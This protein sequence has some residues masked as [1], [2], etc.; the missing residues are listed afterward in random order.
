MKLFK[1]LLLG[2]AIFAMTGCSSGGGKVLSLTI[3][4]SYLTKLKSGDDVK[5]KDTST[6]KEIYSCFTTSSDLKDDSGKEYKLYTIKTNYT[7]EKL[8]NN[9]G[10]EI[11]YGAFVQLHFANENIELAGVPS[12]Y[13]LEDL[14]YV[15]TFTVAP[16]DVK[17]YAS[18]VTL[19]YGEGV[20]NGGSIVFQGKFTIKKIAASLPVE[21]E[22]AEEYNVPDSAKEYALGV[23]VKAFTCMNTAIKRAELYNIFQHA[24]SN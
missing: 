14:N 21:I 23:L 17:V 24:Q 19:D 3:G 15:G 5:V 16:D 1:T 8:N 22:N 2:A 18:Q 10:R 9:G 7:Y 20:Q 12:G 11:S 13:R 4:E 6:E